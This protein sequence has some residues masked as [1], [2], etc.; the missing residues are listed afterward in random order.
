MARGQRTADGLSRCDLAKNIL[1]GEPDSAPLGH[2]PSTP[3]RPG[4]GFGQ[5]V[6]SAAPVTRNEAQSGSPY[7]GPSCDQPALELAI[8]V[9]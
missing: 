8:V 7:A 6:A 1:L 9:I 5:G 2:S 3:T 4:R